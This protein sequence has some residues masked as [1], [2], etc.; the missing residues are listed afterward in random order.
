MWYFGRRVDPLLGIATGVFAFYLN[1]HNPRTAPAPGE[2]LAEVLN[3][4][5]GRLRAEWDARRLSSLERDLE[6]ERQANESEASTK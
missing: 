6:R 1:E 2:S 3:W 5:L 4:R